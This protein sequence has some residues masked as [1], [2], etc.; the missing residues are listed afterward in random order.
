[1]RRP[2]PTIICAS[3]RAST[4][5]FM[6]APLPTLTSS[7]SAST[8]AAS[9]FDMMERRDQRNGFHRGR[10]I[11]QRIQ[12]AVGRRD[13]RRLPDKRQ[14]VLDQLRAEF[15]DRQ[16]G[17]E[18]GNGFQ[19]V[20]R[21]AGMAQRAARKSWEPSRPPLPPAAPR[22]GWS[23]R[24][25]RRWNACPPSRRAPKKD[26]RIS[27]DWIMRSVRAL[28]SR[29]VMP[30]EKYSH[31]KRRHLIIGD[32]AVGIAVNEEGDFF[33]EIA[34]RRPSSDGSGRQFACKN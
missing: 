28:T 11:A 5:F 33:C 15:V 34:L 24:P 17:A 3:R 21:A 10:G 22:S 14:P 8:P 16:I 27:P 13:L 12:L 7:T 23:C 29:S 25:R 2:M 32:V 18:S 9:F 26:R 19:L 6:N 1:M 30:G 20:Q 4:C 31:K